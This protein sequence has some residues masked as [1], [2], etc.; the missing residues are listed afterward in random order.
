MEMKKNKNKLYP[1]YI[2]LCGCIILVQQII[3]CT[4]R[5]MN[6][7]KV[8]IYGHIYTT[9]R[10]LATSFNVEKRESHN[11]K[12]LLIND[13]LCHVMMLVLSI[14]PVQSVN[15][16]LHMIIYLLFVF[17]LSSQGLK[18]YK[19]IHNKLKKQKYYS[20]NKLY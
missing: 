20:H 8:Y 4:N 10:I 1:S 14:C 13:G 9:K 5:C 11:A 2:N 19:Q 16:L 7:S 6:L 12:Y 17:V 3:K 15:C 18:Y